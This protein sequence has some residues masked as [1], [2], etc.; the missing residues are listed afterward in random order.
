MGIASSRFRMPVG[1]MLQSMSHYELV[2]WIALEAID[3]GGEGRADLRA[4]IGTLAFVNTQIT[5]KKKPKLQD[6]M[7]SEWIRKGY[8][9]SA[10][11]RGAAP[12]WNAKKWWSSIMKKVKG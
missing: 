9:K 4:A 11:Q 3:P 8:E 2:H 6:F 5:G 12:A 10:A 7:A 1:L